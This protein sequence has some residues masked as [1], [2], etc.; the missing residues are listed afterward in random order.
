[1]SKLLG[2]FAFGLMDSLR[3]STFTAAGNIRCRKDKS[4]TLNCKMG[5]L[6]LIYSDSFGI[7]KS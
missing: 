6:I 7:L 1:M 4:F 2:L 5:L 3:A